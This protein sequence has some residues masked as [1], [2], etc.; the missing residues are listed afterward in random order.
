MKLDPQTITFAFLLISAVLGGLLLFTWWLNRRVTALAWWGLAF[1]LVV[2]GLLV[3]A[4]QLGIPQAFA[5]IVGNALAA[6]A[7]ALLYTGC[8]AFNNRPVWVPALLA[9]PV[10]WLLAWPFISDWQSARTILMSLIVSAYCSAAAWELWRHAPAAASVPEFRHLAHCGQCPIL[11]TAI[12]SC[13]VWKLGRVACWNINPLVD[14]DCSFLPR[15]CP[16]TAAPPA[17]TATAAA[18]PKSALLGPL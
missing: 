18:T 4:L 12:S 8:R 11:P 15:L 3:A 6:L 2:G 9:G 17:S 14:R 1:W 7:Y 16:R 10:L 5:L 13:C